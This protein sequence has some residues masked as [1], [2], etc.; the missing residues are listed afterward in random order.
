[1]ASGF[2]YEGEWEDGEID[3]IGTATYANGDI[4]VGMFVD[5]KRQGA[6]TMR[7]ASGEEVSGDW[8]DGA[9]ATPAAGGDPAAEEPPSD[10]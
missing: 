1:M 2:V 8:D 6:G 4:Y 7:Y 9:L 10:G 5:G 3:G